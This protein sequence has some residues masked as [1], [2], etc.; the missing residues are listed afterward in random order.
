MSQ[1]SP[2]L[3]F[4]H[5]TFDGSLIPLLIFLS[6]QHQYK[7]LVAHGLPVFCIGATYLLLATF[8]LPEE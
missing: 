8:V 4:M 1:G 6:T 5:L 3:F 7:R 2:W